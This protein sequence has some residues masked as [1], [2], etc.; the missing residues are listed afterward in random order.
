MRVVKA[1][2]PS[3]HWLHG[4]CRASAH[5]HVK[6]GQ[7]RIHLTDKRPRKVKSRKGGREGRREGRR[8]RGVGLDRVRTREVGEHGGV[9]QAKLDAALAHCFVH[10]LKHLLH[11]HRKRRLGG[12]RE[13]GRERKKEV[14]RGVSTFCLGGG[15]GEIRAFGGKR[16]TVSRRDDEGTLKLKPIMVCAP[17]W[18]RRT[19]LFL[20]RGCHPV[21][22]LTSRDCVRLGT[23]SARLEKG[24]REEGGRVKVSNYVRGHRRSVDM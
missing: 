7:S 9:D 24:G 23:Y 5:L 2:A 22:V 4:G 17:S 8:E 6:Q 21:G 19:S 16:K 13:E 20:L 18:K 15:L 12:G 3:W 14:V 11:V 1:G 10:V